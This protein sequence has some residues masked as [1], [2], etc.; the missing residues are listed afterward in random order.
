MSQAII[1]LVTYPQFNPG[2]CLILNANLTH[3]E[4][5]DQVKGLYHN[6]N[7]AQDKNLAYSNN[8]VFNESL[9]PNKI[10]LK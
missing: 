5:L 1:G 8:L 2:E 9:G 4:G 3:S 10:L 7:H 6:K